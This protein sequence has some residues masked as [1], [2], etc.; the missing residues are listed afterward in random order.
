MAALLWAFRRL[1]SANR[2][3]ARRTASLLEANQELALRAKT[4]ALGAVTAHLLHGLKN[5]LSGLERFVNGH[6]AS[7]DAAGDE[8]WRS[9]VATT[10]RLQSLVNEAARV[11]REEEGALSY[12][13]SLLEMVELITAKTQPIAS[14][15][16]VTFAVSQTAAGILENRSANLLA[17]ILFN[18]LQNAIQATPRGK[19]VTLTVADI[20]SGGVECRVVDEGP[21]IPDTV[22]PRLF[23]PVKSAKEGGS[24][25]G[26]AISRQLADHLGASLELLQSSTAGSVFRLRLPPTLFRHASQEPKVGK[27]PA[28]APK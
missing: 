13:L 8:D 18:L 20:A 19:S 25:I 2:E 5:P 10:R 14:E 15:A 21:G 3:L 6:A 1:Q 23:T 4:G 28:I 16:G 24:G 22:R 27:T 7:P 9:A 11:L 26:L 17:L 12:E